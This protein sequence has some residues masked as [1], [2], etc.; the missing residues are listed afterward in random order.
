MRRVVII[1]G[2]LG[3]MWLIVLG[4]LGVV[5]LIVLGSLG[6]VWFILW[7]S[8]VSSS[9]DKSHRITEAERLNISKCLDAAAT[10]V[11]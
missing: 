2:S 11:I 1:L 5:W 7:M 9:P 3:V 8:L 4:S 10:Q 6:V